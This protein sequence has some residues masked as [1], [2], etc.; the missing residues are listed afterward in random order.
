MNCKFTTER[1]LINPISYSKKIPGEELFSILSPDV[2]KSLP[3]E[4]G[5]IISS[6]DAEQWLQNRINE[7]TVLGI[8]LKKGHSLIGFMFMYD[9]LPTIHIGY[10]LGESSWGKGIATEFINGFT[11]W[12]RTEK[13]IT[14]VIGGV[15][16][17]NKP[18]IRVLEKCG[19]KMIGTKEKSTLFYQ[20][21]MS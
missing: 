17:N 16:S 9:D 13:E 3:E 2:M 10:L 6:E 1:L 19:F 18:S 15:D 4:W 8:T 5:K 20:Y 7:S 14:T 11:Q 21:S 12:G